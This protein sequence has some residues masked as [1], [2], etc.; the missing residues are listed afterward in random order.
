VIPADDS[1][2]LEERLADELWLLCNVCWIKPKKGPVQ[3]FI[4][5]PE[6]LE[7]YRTRW[8]RNAILK[9]RQLGFSTLIDLLIFIRCITRDDFTAAIVD[10]RMEDAKKKLGI[11]AR[12]WKHLDSE[13][14]EMC[15]SVGA[16]IKSDLRLVGESKT[17]LVWS[18]GSSVYADTSIRGG[19]LQALHISEL[20]AT[21]ANFPERAEEII[22]GGI[23][24]L[25]ADCFIASESTH[26]GGPFGVHYSLI[27]QA[28]D[29]IG[30]PL[31]K[32][33]W[34]FHWFPW[35]ICEDYRMPDGEI[36][37]SLLTYF[38]DLAALGIKLDTEQQRWYSAQYRTLKHRVRTEY[39]STASEALSA[40]SQGSIYGDIISTL[41]IQGRVKEYEPETALPA[42]TF[43]DIGLSDSTVIWL[44]QFVGREILWLDWVEDSGQPASHYAKVLRGMED[45]HG[46]SIAMNFLPHDA[47]IREK[48]SGV[49]H[50]DH[51]RKAGIH[52][53]TI[54]PRTPDIWSGINVLR[55]LLPRAMFHARCDKGRR[56]DGVDYP[57]GVACLELYRKAVET[58][59]SR[60][61]ELP[62]HDFTSHTA[63]AARTFAEAWERGMIQNMI[64]T[65]EPP[66]RRGHQSVVVKM[67]FS[68]ERKA[69]EPDAE[70]WRAF[71]EP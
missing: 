38:S 10:K 52:R 44:L 46:V 54:V 39:P 14:D 56:K 4:I 71:N 61:K 60:I 62:V 53:L 12:A 16:A 13:K 26:E 24:G 18:N 42:F 57:S 37:G 28:M 3:K 20:A 55:G 41:R 31:S 22:A 69:E 43:W 7:L 36:E 1:E 29:M 64:R 65:G 35:H 34:R 51:L 15:A 8:F 49:T 30:R 40:I 48:G 2:W 66:E 33:D 59:G 25:D 5:R 32:L 68:S 67:G 45:A 27:K 47:D 6:Q 63:D 70:F 58:D 11:I 23:P 17:E 21:A 19:T 9:A 50:A